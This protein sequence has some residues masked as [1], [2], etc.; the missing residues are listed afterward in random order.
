M[1][2]AQSNGVAQNQRYVYNGSRNRL[3]V[4]NNNNNKD[5]DLEN[6]FGSSRRYTIT[7]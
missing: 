4:T 3:Y 6:G 1:Q 2:N 5:G 7:R